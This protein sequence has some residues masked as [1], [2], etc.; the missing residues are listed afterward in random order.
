MFF[1]E[2]RVRVYVDDMKLSQKPISCDLLE[3]NWH[4]YELLKVEM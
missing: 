2:L 1:S 4:L 3:R